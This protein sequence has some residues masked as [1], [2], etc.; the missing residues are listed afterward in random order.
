MLEFRLSNS[1]I[2]LSVVLVT[3]RQEAVTETAGTADLVCKGWT[4]RDLA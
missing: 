3:A 1:D 2:T 4:A